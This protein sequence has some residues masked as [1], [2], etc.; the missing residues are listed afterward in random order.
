[1]LALI[2]YLGITPL[3][4]GSLITTRRYETGSVTWGYRYICGLMLS[5]TLFTILCIP[6]IRFEAPF[7]VLCMAYE[8]VTVIA[9]LTGLVLFI[10][11]RDWAISV[12]WKFD[13][14]KVAPF[15]LMALIVG[16]QM[17]R[18]FYFQEIEYRDDKTYF[19][20]VNDMLGSDK[21]YLTDP[22]NGQVYTSIFEAN[23]KDMMDSWY[24][25]AAFLSRVSH[26]HPLV[27][28]KT[29]LPPLILF[30][31]Y[32]ILWIMGMFLFTQDATK[33]AWFVTIC[34][35]INDMTRQLMVTS[36]IFLDWPVWGKNLVGT[37]SVLLVL[38]I[39]MRRSVDSRKL[40]YLQMI[41]AVTMGGFT[42]SMGLIAMPL[43]IGLLSLIEGVRKKRIIPIFEA[44]IY[45]LPA[46]LG[47]GLLVLYRLNGVETF[48]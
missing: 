28:C 29:V 22:N 12:K 39:Y 34:A 9:T 35:L 8:V 6:M 27:I 1:M 43:E 11:R 31:H 45:L 37:I 10:R 26:F 3:I 14:A 2:F 42:S 18:L 47:L 32:L 16:F 25:Y 48:G 13:L 30:W 4:M 36:L 21:M 38:V 5:Y 41:C 20:L 24:P 44:I 15:I 17:F 19:A 7:H 33:T 40:N 46:I 23:F